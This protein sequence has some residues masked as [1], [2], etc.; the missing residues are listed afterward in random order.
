MQILK[1][2]QVL[3]TDLTQMKVC[4]LIQFQQSLPIQKHNTWKQNSEQ[5]KKVGEN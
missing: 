3:F 2:E 1:E 5:K 4:L